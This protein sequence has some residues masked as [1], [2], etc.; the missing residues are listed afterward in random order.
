M[1]IFDKVASG[2]KM[3]GSKGKHLRER[4]NNSIREVGLWDEVKDRLALGALRPNG[5]DGID[6]AHPKKEYS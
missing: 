3:T 4:V 2:P 5:F 1:S 6:A